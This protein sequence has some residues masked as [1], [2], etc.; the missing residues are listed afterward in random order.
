MNK[1]FS[2]LVSQF[3]DFYKNLTPV[4]RLSLLGAAALTLVSIMI[5]SVMITGTTYEVLLDDIPNEQVAV[6]V[7][8]LE[9]NNIPYRLEANGKQVVVPKNLRHSAQMVLMTQLGPTHASLIG[10]ELF[11]KQDFGITTFA[12]R[13]NYQRALQG[14]LMR[15]INTLSA[16]KKSKVNLALPPKKTFLEE[17]GHPTASVVIEMHPGKKLSSDQ[18]SGITHLVANAVQNMKPEDVTVVDALGKILSK[19]GDGSSAMSAELL[20]IKSKIESDLESRV[21]SMLSKAVGN[22]KVTAEVNVALNQKKVATIQESVD[23]DA[24]AVLGSAVEEESLNGARTNPA[25]IPGARANLPGADDQGEVGFRQNVVRTTNNTNF[26][27]PKTVRNIEEAPGAIERISL[28]I[29]VDGITT[30]KTN[31]NGEVVENYS[32]R[33]TEELQKLV[34]LAKE[35]VGFSEKRGDSVRIE[36]LRFQKEDFSEAD[37][38][39]TTLDRKKLVRSLFKWTLLGLSLSLFF[40]IVV[41]PFMRW[42]TDSFQDSVEDLLPRTIEELEELQSVDNTLPGMSGALPVLEEALDPDKSESELLKERIMSLMNR[43]VEKASGA[44]SLWLVRR[45]M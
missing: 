5:I 45:D 24:T 31:E 4:R 16:V 26:V 35:A 37:R 1:L 32:E 10:L 25:G 14:E 21:I 34:D 41:R 19:K 36:N 13:V 20:D 28:A 15:S 42:I 18:V 2:H 33:P 38:L 27:V 40:F 22:G 11:E 29:M 44:F 23:P 39:L 3:R 6:V 9:Q 12:Q 30:M 43:D 8:Q 17:A 7:Q